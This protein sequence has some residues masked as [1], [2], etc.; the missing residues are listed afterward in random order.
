[1]YLLAFVWAIFSI[2]WLLNDSLYRYFYGL[3][4][5]AYVALVVFLGYHLQRKRRWSW[6]AAL[7]L[8]GLS[9]VATFLDQVG[10]IDLAYLGLSVIVFVILI[11]QRKQF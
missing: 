11:L 3:L 2:L 5:L 1:M 8:V 7:V 9:I 6:W 4:G 10:W